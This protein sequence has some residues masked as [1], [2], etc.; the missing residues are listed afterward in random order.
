VVG[1]A[2]LGEELPR[3]AERTLT[4]APGPAALLL[5]GA[6][7]AALL[8]ERAVTILVLVAVL[9]AVC[10]RAPSGRRWPYLVG[11]LGSGLSV[12]L[13]SPFVAVVGVDVLWEGPIVPV[14]GPLDV[15]SEEIRIAAV[16]GGRLAAVG[17]AFA[18]Y[19]LLVDHDRLIAGAGFARRSA[20]AVAL[21]TRLVPTL[22][23][24]AAGFAEA[25]E[26]R[27]VAVAGIRGHARLLSPLVAGSLERATNLAEAMEARG[28]GRPER[29]KAPGMRWSRLDR[30]ALV[31]AAA[32]VA[33][34]ALWL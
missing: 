15:T 7:A 27:G 17:L 24:D 12:F 9:L 4:L 18:A 16:N 11:S 31:G 21:A 5:A 20:L 22:E 33:A 1:P 13:L 32:L 3:P 23:R 6:A 14:L 30:A 10:L 25:M 19:A 29:T 28:F 8:A 34:A 26:G 2:R